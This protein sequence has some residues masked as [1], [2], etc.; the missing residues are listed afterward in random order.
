[1]R[2]QIDAV[3]GFFG[4]HVLFTSANDIS[5]WHLRLRILHVSAH[6]IDG[7]YDNATGQ[8]KDGREPVPFTRDFGEI[9]ASYSVKIRDITLMAYSG[10]SYATLV[11]P[12]DVQRIATLQGV[13][14]HSSEL[15]GQALGR[16]VNIFIADNVSFIGVPSYVGTNNL[17]FGVKFGDWNSAGLRLYGSYYTGLDVF[18]Q[19]YNVRRENWGLGFAFDFW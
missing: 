18:S 10:I 17:E 3:D 12:T 9:V 2:L 14:L 7:H 16:P 1:L 5:R 13:E 11:R 6:F 19:Y 4:G 15:V 8:W